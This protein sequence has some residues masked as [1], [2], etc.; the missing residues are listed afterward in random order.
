MP[1]PQIAFVDVISWAIRGL[2]FSQSGLHIYHRIPPVS[3]PVVDTTQ[4]QDRQALSQ[5]LA[6]AISP[7]G[8]KD[9]DA[10]L[11]DLT[12]IGCQVSMPAELPQPTVMARLE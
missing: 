9:L 6:R 10:L 2:F 8:V 7:E 3:C 5:L 11:S 12:A 1:N 4:V